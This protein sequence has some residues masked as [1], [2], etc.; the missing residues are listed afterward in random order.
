MKRLLYL[1]VSP[2]G[3]ASHSR[4]ATEEY[5][6]HRKTGN[7][8]LLVVERDLAANPVPHPDA[9][10]VGASPAPPNARDATQRQALSLSDKRSMTTPF[11]RLL[12]DTSPTLRGTGLHAASTDAILPAAFHV[13]Q[14]CPGRARFRKPPAT[15]AIPYR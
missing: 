7:P 11:N 3:A 12:L 6:R 9:G 13:H 14:N 10:F 15:A 5:L 8:G 2:R 1:A 4:R